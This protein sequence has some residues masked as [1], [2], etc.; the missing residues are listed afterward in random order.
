[1]EHKC[2]EERL[3]AMDPIKFR[4]KELGEKDICEIKIVLPP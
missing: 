3:V 1:M 2:Y 4:F